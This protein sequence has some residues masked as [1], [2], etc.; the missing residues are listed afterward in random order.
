MPQQNSMTSSPRWISP[1]LSA[2]TLPCSDDSRCA[3]SSMF[4][5]TSSLNRNITRARRCG[6]VAAQTGCAACAAVT[7]QSRSACVPSATVA[8]TWPVFGL[9][10]SPIRLLPPPPW[11]AIRWSMVRMI[12]PL[13]VHLPC[14]AVAA[15]RA[16]MHVEAAIMQAEVDWSDLRLFLALARTGRLAAAGAQ[17]GQDATTVSRRMRRLETRLQTR[18]FETGASGRILSEQGRILLGRAEAMEREAHGI[19]EDAGLGTAAISGT[20]R[21]SVSEGFGSHV[22]APRLPGFTRAWPEVTVELIASSGFLNPSRREAD[23]AVLL[24]R[25]K[26]G[27]LIVRKL[28]DYRLGLY[29]AR[30]RSHEIANVPRARGLN[31]SS[32]RRLRSRPHLCAG[33]RLSRGDRSSAAGQHP[34]FQYQCASGARWPRCRS[35][36]VA[37]FHRRPN[38]AP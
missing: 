34:Q 15:K 1:L 7:A 31:R 2:I 3:S 5:S 10:T 20:I 27:P 35:W 28:T 26:S 25:P 16:W 9:N 30:S 24:S 38:A 13:A 33:T 29:G 22:L 37:L 18:L 17:I 14:P 6:L 11:P 36:R 32:T 19:I 21:L 23:L 8:C 4:C 12:I